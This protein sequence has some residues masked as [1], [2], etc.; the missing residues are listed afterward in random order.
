MK[1][2]SKQLFT[3]G[4]FLSLVI[5]LLLAFTTETKAA[6]YQSSDADYEYEADGSGVRIVK[7]TGITLQQVPDPVYS[8]IVPNHI[9]KRFRTWEITIVYQK[10]ILLMSPTNM[11]I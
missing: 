1:K 11:V 8:V 2:L 9:D 7:Y 10:I 4:S 5:V 6:A 3:L